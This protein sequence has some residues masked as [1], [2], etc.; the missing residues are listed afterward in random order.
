MFCNKG[1]LHICDCLNRCSVNATPQQMSQTEQVV[2][3]FLR[4][5]ERRRLE[6]EPERPQVV[7]VRAGQA[8]GRT[9]PVCDMGSRHPHCQ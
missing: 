3:D 1:F 4:S 5:L 8:P 7:Q 9:G 6:Q 2:G